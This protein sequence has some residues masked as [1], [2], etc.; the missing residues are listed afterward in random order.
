MDF[1]IPGAPI[2]IMGNKSLKPENSNYFSMSA[3]YSH[4]TFNASVIA[5]YNDLNNLITEVYSPENTNKP[6]F[7][8]QY[9]N[10]A[11]AEMLNMEVIF[12]YKPIPQMKF[13]GG[14]TWTKPLTSRSEEAINRFEARQHSAVMTGEYSVQYGNYR[15]TITLQGKYFGD[16]NITWTDARGQNSKVKLS[17]YF[18]WKLTTLHRITKWASATVGIDNLF[19]YTDTRYFTSMSPGRRIFAGVKFNW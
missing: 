2:K 18:N 1:N 5:Q 7:I 10:I 11:K 13:S 17:E 8:Y 14:Y 4:S 19:N 3:E 6:P 12:N 15:P 9:Q 16:A